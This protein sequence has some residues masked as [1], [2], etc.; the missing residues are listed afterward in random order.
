[1]LFA[2]WGALLAKCAVQ[3]QMLQAM[4][5]GSDIF[6]DP[7]TTDAFEARLGMLSGSFFP[8]WSEC[9]RKCVE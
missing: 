8:G 1:M 6:H 7:Q 9:N 4:D 5:L 3:F 2:R